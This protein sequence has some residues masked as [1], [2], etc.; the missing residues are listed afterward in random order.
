MLHLSLFYNSHTGLIAFVTTSRLKEATCR[1]LMA[2]L[3]VQSG[4]I[5]KIQKKT[6]KCR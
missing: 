2:N 6:F 3:P 5:A 4:S 1:L